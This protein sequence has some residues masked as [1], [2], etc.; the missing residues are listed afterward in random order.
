MTNPTTKQIT[1]AIN[2]L[3]AYY[4]LLPRDQD[5]ASRSQACTTIL[6]LIDQLPDQHTTTTTTSIPYQ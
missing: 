2:T 5:Y 3:K 4:D 1:D 6:D